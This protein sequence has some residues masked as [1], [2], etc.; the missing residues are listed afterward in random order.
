MDKQK[1]P[2]WTQ[3]KKQLV[4]LEAKELLEIIGE[5]YKLN[6]DN[7]VFLTSQLGQGNVAELVEPYRQAIK[8]EFN[9]DRGFPRISV[10]AARKALNNFKK[11]SADPIAVADL[12]IF[13]VE[14]GVICTNNYGDI[15]ENFYSSLESVYA[16]AVALL[17]R[18]ANPDLIEQFRPRLKWIVTNTSGIGWGFHDELSHIYYTQYPPE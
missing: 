11:S 2:T 5:L 8:R 15:D 3:I 10:G 16:D 6:Q 12:M 4:Q 18:L 14:Q 9:P 13:Y 1:S 7:K 17:R